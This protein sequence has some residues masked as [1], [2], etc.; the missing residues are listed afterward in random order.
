[1][2]IRRRRE[3]TRCSVALDTRAASTPS[4]RELCQ[5][6]PSERHEAAYGSQDAAGCRRHCRATE[7]LTQ[8]VQMRVTQQRGAVLR[9]ELH[10]LNKGRT[11][12][13]SSSTA[14]CCAG[15]RGDKPE[16]APHVV[17]PSA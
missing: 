8:H 9:F 15:R 10:N 7:D 1:M 4:V 11:T 13:T 14:I 2:R 5:S 12:T 17:T 16:V 6:S 3:V